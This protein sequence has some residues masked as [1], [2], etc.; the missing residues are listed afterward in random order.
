MA[1]KHDYVPARDADF[2]KW[3]VFL[4]QY[5]TAKC[6]DE[7]WTHIPQ[8]ALTAL[9]AV[10]SAWSTAWKNVQGPH[11]A[12]DT[13]AK[14]DAKKAAK[15]VIRPFVNQYL[16]FPPVTDE[17]RTAMGIPNHDS[18]RTPIETPQ[19][20]PVFAA[21]VR[22]IRSVTLVFHDEG[23][24]SSAI[25][26]GFNGA[27]VSWD[28][29]GTPVTDPKKLTRSELA[30]RSPHVL[31]FEEEDRG[32]TVYI[33]LQWQNESGEKGDFTAVQTAIIP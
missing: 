15:A 27:V 5:V 29:S 23:T 11:T 9:T 17:D 6:A 4:V 3:F 26:Y 28:V 31:H 25:P 16:R 18:T 8:A 19:T 30:T 21:E 20:V 12:V 14:N 32:K 24:K 10:R 13:E 22:G 33:A 7:T 1:H 2:D